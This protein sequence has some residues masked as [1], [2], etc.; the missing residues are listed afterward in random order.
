M[1][2]VKM[3]GVVAS[4]VR[5]QRAKERPSLKEAKEEEKRPIKVY[6]NC[7]IMWIIGILVRCIIYR[8]DKLS[9]YPLKKSSL[10]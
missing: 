5:K 8:L 7:D 4:K 9:L 6:S 10:K 2:K 3:A 1:K